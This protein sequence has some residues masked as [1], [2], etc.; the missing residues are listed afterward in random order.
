MNVRL[1]CVA[2]LGPALVA[3][4]A[5]AQSREP[6]EPRGHD[7]GE[8]LDPLRGS[9]FV[10][11]QSLSTQ[12]AH[13]EPSPQLSY[14]PFYGWWLSLRPRWNFTPKLR[15]QAR[16][17]YYKEFTNSQATT[18]RSEDVF[19]DLWTEIVYASPVAEHGP[20]SRTTWSVGGR[21]LWPTSKQSRGAGVYV[22]LGAFAGITEDVPIRGG[23]AAYLNSA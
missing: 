5:A 16:F 7:S 20:W 14:V 12:G 1:W 10:F 19:D 21:A 9:V 3:G 8:G 13:L 22:T 6:E 17:D 18:Y 4:N 15:L 23:Y 2:I 11:D